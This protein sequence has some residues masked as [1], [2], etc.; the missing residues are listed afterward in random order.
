[1]CAL[2][3]GEDAVCQGDTDGWTPHSGVSV[4]GLRGRGIQTYTSHMAWL[5]S[6]KTKVIFN[7]VMRPTLGRDQTAY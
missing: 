4:C 7:T 3:E 6:V 5:M 2:Y 1:M